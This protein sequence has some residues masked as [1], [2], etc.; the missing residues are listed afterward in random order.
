MLPSFIITNNCLAIFAKSKGT[1]VNS[2]F[3]VKFLESWYSLDKYYIEIL[4]YLN[5]ITFFTLVNQKISLKAVQVS[6]K[7][8]FMDNPAIAKVIKI[9]VLRDQWLIQ[10]KKPNKNTKT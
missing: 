8:K 9:T 3:C 6:K 2:D 5:N 1:F 7:I 10:D 4:A